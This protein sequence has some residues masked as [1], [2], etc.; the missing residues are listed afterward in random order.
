MKKWKDESTGET[1]DAYVLVMKD[2][3][4]RI[5]RETYSFVNDMLALEDEIFTEEEIK[6]HLAVMMS[7]F[8]PQK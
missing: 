1:R 8:P 2:V 3:M 6:K 7:R 5:S 4:W